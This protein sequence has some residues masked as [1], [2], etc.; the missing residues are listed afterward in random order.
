MTPE[1]LAA[2]AELA[3]RELAR[4]QAAAEE[5]PLTL[6]TGELT[7]DEEDATPGAPLAPVEPVPTR[8]PVTEAPTMP[9][10]FEPVEDTQ[11]RL[12]ELVDQRVQDA[13]D[14]RDELLKPEQVDA[15]VAREEA[16]A[17]RDIAEQREQMLIAGQDEPVAPT[18]FFPPGRPTRM[19]DGRQRVGAE[20]DFA[21]FLSQDVERLYRDPDTGKLRPAT[22]FEELVETFAA[23]PVMTEAEARRADEAV[24]E[25]RDAIR[26]RMQAGEQISPAE[27]QLVDPSMSVSRSAKAVLDYAMKSEAETGG[28]YESMLAA[29]LRATPAFLSALLREGYFTG[30]GYDV[31]A[32][33]NPVDKS[34]IGYQIAQARDFVGLPPVMTRFGTSRLATPIPLPGVA[35]YAE[36]QQGVEATDPDARRQRADADL[37]LLRRIARDVTNDR[38]LGDEFADSPEYR[39]AAFDV[40][41]SEDA[42]F[43]LGTGGEIAIP[44]GP[45]TA[46]R[47]AAKLVKGFAGIT[48]ESPK[49]ARLAEALISKAEASSATRQE[50]S[51]L[52]VAADLAAVVTK[53]KASDGRIVRHVADQMV[54]AA[55]DFSKADKSKMVQAVKPT[56]NTSEQ[57]TRDM[58]RAIDRSPTDDAFERLRVEIDLRTPDDMV[59]VS[60]AIAVPRALA[61]QT[62]RVMS[63]AVLRLQRAETPD[64]QALILSVYGMES[65]ADRVRRAGGIAN[66]DPRLQNVMRE[67]VKKVAALRF[68]PKIAK[69]AR[70][71]DQVTEFQVYVNRLAEITPSVIKGA[72]GPLVRRLAATPFGS[73]SYNLAVPTVSVLRT[74]KALKAAGAAASRQLNRALQSAA[75]NSKTADEA[76]DKVAA[77]ELADVPAETLYRR[78]VAEMYGPD[79]V[80]DLVTA[81]RQ[82]QLVEGTP[83]FTGPV[84]VQKLRQI[85]EIGIARGIISPKGPAP[86]YSRSL[87]R[88]VLEEG[89]RKR[90]ALGG[91]E[92]EA[93][94]S[95]PLGRV[96]KIEDTPGGFFRVPDKFD[97]RAGAPGS[98]VRYYRMADQKYEAKLA[99]SVDEFVE[100]IG[101]EAG[102]GRFGWSQWLSTQTNRLGRNLRDAEYAMRYGYYLPNL[103]YLSGRMLALPIVSIATIGAEN[104]MRALARAAGRTVRQGANLFPGGRRLGMGLS[105]PQGV[106]YSP[107]VLDDLL[108]VHGGLGKTAIQE[109]RAGRLARDIM[110]DVERVASPRMKRLM[111]DASARPDV[112]NFFQRTAEAIELSYRRSVFEAGIANGLLPSDA[113]QL[114]RKSLL[115]LSEVPSAITN[116]LGYFF[117][118]AGEFFML[119]KEFAKLATRNP[120]KLTKIAKATRAKQKAQDRYGL[121]GD[122]S[123]KTLGVFP[124]GREGQEIDVYGPASPHLRPI[125]QTLNGIRS[126]DIFVSRLL[127]AG[128]LLGSNDMPG[129]LDTGLEAPGELV[130]YG[131]SALFPKVLDAFEKQLGS[132]I[133]PA[134]PEGVDL[135]EISDEDF[136]WASLIAADYADPRHEGVFLSTT[137]FLDAEVVMPPEELSVPGEPDLWSVQPEGGTPFLAMGKTRDGIDRYKVYK[138]TERGL[139]NLR[140][141][142]ALPIGAIEQTFGIGASYLG[143][144]DNVDVEAIFPT[145]APATIGRVLGGRAEPVQTDTQRRAAMTE[146]IRAVREDVQ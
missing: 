57:I 68:V 138:P 104:T 113:A 118:D 143:S 133:G 140:T 67:Q 84:T 2:Q 43:W 42:A 71:T 124:A 8:L 15:F 64:Q 145:G 18:T 53:G 22:G 130:R 88:A 23:Q 25:Q 50:R 28:V 108:E 29:T 73:R 41:G 40:Y 27:A 16:R 62:E 21:G 106:Y 94:L 123:L 48:G 36:R 35:R 79:K 31:D 101:G 65:Y 100:V 78:M 96:T 55:G 142:R 58:A 129:A 127:E 132:E 119:A 139:R 102:T 52:N 9:A 33:G 93:A 24:Q 74:T 80:D 131:A 112:R 120:E 51:M 12:E 34:D 19:V 56:S 72:Y 125:E 109:A 105:D 70:K 77:A 7:L 146:D 30:F 66:L 76:L 126:A 110:R 63:D 135:S 128:K 32:D 10:Q 137:D 85:D 114:A 122:R 89:V 115:N 37:D 26:F 3:R 46:A 86:E 17:K 111:M 83:L 6:F 60:E 49:A 59:L 38:T 141:I 144:R 61:V 99:K 107:K 20:G 5:Q 87:L 11:R 1:Q 82:E 14:R 92:F 98:M 47:G 45:G 81:L 39:K 116:R 121:E 95:A 90:I 97:P 75:K 44:A 134:G 117:A 91:K 103:P 54:D 4:R 13:L 69:A 136:F